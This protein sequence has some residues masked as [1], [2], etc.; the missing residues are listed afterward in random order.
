[1]IHRS[2]YLI[3]SGFS[4]DSEIIPLISTSKEGFHMGSIVYLVGAVVI[5]VVVLKLIGLY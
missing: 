2:S 5:V 4:Q 1:M 3:F